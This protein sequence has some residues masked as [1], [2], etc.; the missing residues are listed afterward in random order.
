M[1]SVLSLEFITPPLL[2][3][4]YG[5][6]SSSHRLKRRLHKGDRRGNLS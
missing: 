5:G 3:S 2:T 1:H 4:F 6:R